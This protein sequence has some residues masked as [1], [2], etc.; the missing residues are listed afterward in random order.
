[1]ADEAFATAEDY[2]ARYPGDATTADEQV[3]VAI[4][5]AS[6]MIRVKVGDTSQIASS[7]LTRLTCLA[8]NRAIQAQNT[9]LNGISSIQR[10]AGPYSV[11]V[12][13][14][15]NYGGAYLLD[16]EWAQIGVGVAKIGFMSMWP[17]S[18]D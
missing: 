2:R 1:M 5:D 16:D 11:M 7:T 17:S 9:D 14:S 18:G 12:T 4:I 8:A 3:T 13:P 15:K 6:D 10:T